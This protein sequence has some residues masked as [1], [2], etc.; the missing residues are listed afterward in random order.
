MDLFW[1]CDL[2]FCFVV[3]YTHTYSLVCIV[4]DISSGAKNCI[5]QMHGTSDCS[6]LLNCLLISIVSNQPMR[7]HI[8]WKVAGCNTWLVVYL[9]TFLGKRDERVKIP[10]M[11]QWMNVQ[12]EKKRRNNGRMNKFSFNCFHAIEAVSCSHFYWNNGWFGCSS[13][14]LTYR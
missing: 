2:Y 4:Y 7:I 5:K 3:K 14:P 9:S 13:E 12:K 11:K 8:A 6:Q 10:E 1:V